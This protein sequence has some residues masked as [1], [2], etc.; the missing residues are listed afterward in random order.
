MSTKTR[1]FS[2]FMAFCMILSFF[3]VS[4]A[5]AVHFQNEYF[6]ADW[7][8]GLINLNN[9]DEGERVTSVDSDPITNRPT[10]NLYTHDSDW[11]YPITCQKTG[12]YRISCTGL[13]KNFQ[14]DDGVQKNY[15]IKCDNKYLTIPAYTTADGQVQLYCNSTANGD[16]SIVVFLEAGKEYKFTSATEYSHC[17]IEYCAPGTTVNGLEVVNN[18]DIV[19]TDFDTYSKSMNTLA[20]AKDSELYLPEGHTIYYK[21]GEYGSTQAINPGGTVAGSTKESASDSGFEIGLVNLF[22][23]VGDFLMKVIDN[24]VGES[25][26]V[27]KLV[28]NDVK[29]V[30]ANF[31]DGAVQSNTFGGSDFRDALNNWYQIFKSFAIVVYLIAL[32]AIGIHV[33]FNST[34]A[35]TQKARELISEW[36]KGVIILFFIP[37]GMKWI[38]EFNET[39]IKTIKPSDYAPQSVGSSLTSSNEWSAEDIEFRSPKFISLYTGKVS[40][41]TEEANNAYLKNLTTYKNSFDLMRIMR[42]YAGATGKLGYTLLWYVLIGQLIVFIFIYYKRY[43]MI[44]FLIAVF[45]VVCLFNAISI[46]KGKKGPQFST[47]LK[48]FLTN[49]FTQFIHA[50]IYTIITGIIVSIIKDNLTVSGGALNWIIVIVSINFV[51][52]GEKVVKKFITAVGSGKTGPDMQGGAG[53]LKNMYHNATSNIRQIMGARR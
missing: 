30:N 17:T 43:F 31:F 24:V 16:T 33:L 5:Y 13:S 50:L 35:G 4:Y 6:K 45:P 29:A 36:A 32:L 2:A 18:N 22:L 28:Y 39:L 21:D 1:F 38:F 44:A 41:G 42:A 9:V 49:V 15:C 26:T 34:A 20:G 8:W 51:P 10:T 3:S 53:G 23:G 40:Y 19:I 47:W 7:T 48:E 27:T 52:E 25:V 14:V 11:G 37:I 46:I 12:L